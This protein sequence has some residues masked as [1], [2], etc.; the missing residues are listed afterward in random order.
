M[1]N[2]MFCKYKNNKEECD[3]KIFD[4]NW[5][6]PTVS[7]IYYGKLIKY[8]PFNTIEKVRDYILDKRVEKYYS[9]FNE[10][11]T[12][13]DE[14]KHI[15][16]I[17]SYADLGSK[18]PNLTSMN[19]LD[20]TYLK[21]E[22]KYILG[23]ETLLG[24]ESDEKCKEYMEWLLEKF[25]EWMKE[26]GYNTDVVLNMCEVF[27]EGI[28]INTHFDDIETAYATFKLLVKGFEGDGL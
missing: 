20:L 15:F 21:D 26:N 9:E 24:F 27:T 4:N 17:L 10:D 25:T 18:K 22:D 13:N 8:F 12:E 23:V 1:N 3:K 28:N 11:F 5:H 2:C 6:C 19:D 7:N 14:M 16:G